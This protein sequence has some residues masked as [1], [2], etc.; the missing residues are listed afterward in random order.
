M[1]YNTSIYGIRGRLHNKKYFDNLYPINDIRIKK[2]IPEII[3]LLKD[4]DYYVQ[5]SSIWILGELGAK[6]A[7]PEIKKLLGA[8]SGLIVQ[9]AEEALTKLGVPAG[10]RR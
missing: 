6:E 5:R 2:S 4:N 7:I 1:W 3:R 9:E 10:R 8:K